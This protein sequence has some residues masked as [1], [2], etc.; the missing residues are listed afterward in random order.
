MVE[1]VL[2]LTFKKILHRPT[3]E[4]FPNL[5]HCPIARQKIKVDNRARFRYQ[6]G[7]GFRLIDASICGASAEADTQFII[8]DSSVF[9]KQLLIFQADPIPNITYFSLLNYKDFSICSY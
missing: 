4:L 6:V 7:Y 1:T 3:G 2:K 9:E 5:P 8:F